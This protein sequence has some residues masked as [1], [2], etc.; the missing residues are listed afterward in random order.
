MSEPQTPGVWPQVW[1]ALAAAAA[2]ALVM[3]AASDLFDLHWLRVYLVQFGALGGFAWSLLRHWHKRFAS[4]EAALKTGSSRPVTPAAAPVP[5]PAASGPAVAGL[6]TSAAPPR[7]S[8]RDTRTL[9]R[10]S[11]C[12]GAWRKGSGAFFRDGQNCCIT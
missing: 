8:A 2:G 1:R 6:E 5:K 3:A 11:G 9:H 7:D 10:R 4:L 12:G